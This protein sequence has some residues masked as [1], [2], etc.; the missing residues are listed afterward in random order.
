M[1]LSD[2]LHGWNRRRIVARRLSKPAKYTPFGF[3]MNAISEMQDGRFE[4]LET[5]LVRTML[6]RT[7]RFVNV[8]ANMGF[9]CL[10]SAQAGVETMALEPVP[11][12][13]R[14]IVDNMRAN[15]WDTAVTL[16]PVA[17]G[18]EPGFVDIYG[19]GTGSSVLKEWGSNPE[20]TR[21]TVS[22]VRLDDVI[23]SPR[24]DERMFILMDIEGYETFA[25]KGSSALINAAT[26]PVWL[27]EIV[28]EGFEG[29]INPQAQDAF[30][31][32][33]AAG[34]QAVCVDETLAPAKGPTP[35]ATNFLFFDKALTLEDVLGPEAERIAPLVV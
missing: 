28:G 6:Q 24:T 27:I 2:I 13:V 11:S 18:A 15:G 23:A 12:N 20:S 16:L 29:T 5:A 32:M 33:L 3:M 35:S 8:G 25:L 10:L 30:D 14:F 22:A 7:D 31:M 26:K 4:P 17:A 1:D 21:Q 34:Y 9:Y 19:V